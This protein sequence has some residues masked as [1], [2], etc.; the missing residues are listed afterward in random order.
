MLGEDEDKITLADHGLGT[1]SVEVILKDL[2]PQM[3]ELEVM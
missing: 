2:G 1:S 3:C